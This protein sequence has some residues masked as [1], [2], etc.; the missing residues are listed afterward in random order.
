[1]L[2]TGLSKLLF[3]S[4]SHDAIHTSM[5]LTFILHGS[6]CL[7]AHILTPKN[8]LAGAQFPEASTGS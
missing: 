1:M 2:D 4:W 8:L 7:R 3:V 6:M 5:F